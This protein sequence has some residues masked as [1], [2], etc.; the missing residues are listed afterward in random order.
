MRTD[1]L[2]AALRACGGAGRAL[3]LV[4]FIPRALRDGAYRCVARTRY[5]LFGAW[6]PRPLSR[7]EWAARFIDGSRS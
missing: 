6:R 4:R 1:G 7:P 5:R 3:A 2:V